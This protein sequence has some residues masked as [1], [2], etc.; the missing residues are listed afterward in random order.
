MQVGPAPENISSQQS[1][2]SDGFQT[3]LSTAGGFDRTRVGGGVDLAGCK[4]SWREVEREGGWGCWE[5][6]ELW[7]E[8]GDEMS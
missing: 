3:D 2:T 4:T 5:S 6:N 1:S 7:P 8:M